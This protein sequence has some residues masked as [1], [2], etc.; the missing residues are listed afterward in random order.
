MKDH[1]KGTVDLL[2]KYTPIGLVD[3]FLHPQE[4]N[5]SKFS[6]QGKIRNLSV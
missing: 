5:G 2:T 1:K 3:D 6:L 4:N